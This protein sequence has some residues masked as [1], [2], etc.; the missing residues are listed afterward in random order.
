M[1]CGVQTL[2]ERITQFKEDRTLNTNCSQSEVHRL[3]LDSVLDLRAAKPLAEAF[4]NVK[5]ADIVVDAS[6]VERIGAQCAQVLLSAMKTWEAD[7]HTLSFIDE[8]EAFRE[9][10]ALLGLPLTDTQTEG[11]PSCL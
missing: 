9:G 4:L 11:D 2:T 6:K 3:T 10:A 1:I 8:S 5:G 7:H